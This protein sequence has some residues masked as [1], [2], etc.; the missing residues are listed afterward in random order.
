MAFP[1]GTEPNWIASADLDGDNDVDL[2]TANLSTT[3]I[4]VLMNNGNAT[5]ASAITLTVGS[6]P[7]CVVA[8]DIDGDNDFDLVTANQNTDNISVLRNN[9]NGTFATQ[10]QYAAGSSPMSVILA[11]VDNDNDLD[12][13]VGGS[14]LISIFLNSG[15]GIFVPAAS[16][17]VAGSIEGVAAGD[18]DA[19]GDRDLVAARSYDSVAVVKN[20]GNG[21]F[22]SPVSFSIL[23]GRFSK[24]VALADFD[25]DGDLDVVSANQ[26]AVTTSVLFNNGD[27]SFGAAT[28]FAT[29][30]MF[31]FGMS[32][33][34]RDMNEDG[35]PD[36]IIAN[37]GNA[38]PPTVSVLINRGNGTFRSALNVGMLY[39]RVLPFSSL[40][41]TVADFDGDGHRD[42]A[43]SGWYSFGFG[44]SVALALNR[45]A[46]FDYPVDYPT[47]TTPTSIASADFDGDNDKDIVVVNNGSGTFSVRLN[48]GNGTFAPAV[49]YSAGVSPYAVSVGDFDN[50]SDVDIIAS[51]NVTSYFPLKVFWNDGTG[52]FPSGTV[53][54]GVTLFAGTVYVSNADVDADSDEDIVSAN[55]GV[56]NWI[57]RN[58]GNRTFTAS[59]IGSG[60][61]NYYAQLGDVDGDGDKDYVGPMGRSISVRKNNGNGTFTPEAFTNLGYEQWS[62]ALSDLDGDGDLDLSTALNSVG[63]GMR[64]LNGGSGNFSS[65]DTFA[66]GGGNQ[67]KVTSGDFDGD[68]DK[69]LA[70]A[71][72]S[73]SNVTIMTNNGSGSFSVPIA[74]AAGLGPRAITSGD[75]DGD[76]DLDLAVANETSN[77]VSI[78]FNRTV[79]VGVSEEHDNMPQTFQ[80]WQ[81]YPNPFNPSTAI[82]YSLPV[83]SRVIL[84]VYD[85]LGREVATL[86]DDIQ[87]AGFKTVEWD[88]N[89]V[90][91]GVYFYRIVAGNFRDVRR[92]VLVK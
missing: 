76:G 4:S 69:D 34:A 5:F 44:N 37:G 89:G 66:Y 39:T 29:G 59:S 84:K 6:R 35:R 75:F 41:V 56:P 50:D 48:N 80:L 47:G 20:N 16:Y 53:I 51:Q 54:D 18:L 68:G 2:V 55:E 10:V 70:Y 91:S 30:D 11:D 83:Q 31:T 86:V 78:L 52:V 3:T 42:I 13:A 60:W 12:V 15:T 58:N 65:P 32:V 77:D 26:N 79:S 45:P 88:V 81:N 40:G 49:S 87:D 7:R 43:A 73:A 1:T 61:P 62:L 72:F 21:T 33:E 22:G 23:P 82:R 36:I 92:M 38:A 8:A 85:M 74:Y 24:R 25:A 57:V 63:I 64:L 90:A 17:G 27:G 67:A 9:G 28:T 71:S 19:D 46:I 14:G